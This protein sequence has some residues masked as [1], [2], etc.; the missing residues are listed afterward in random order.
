MGVGFY[1]I[2]TIKSLIRVH[3]IG[4]QILQKKSK[5]WPNLATYVAPPNDIV[6]QFAQC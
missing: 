3:K 6:L 4:H 5:L 2:L 1:Y